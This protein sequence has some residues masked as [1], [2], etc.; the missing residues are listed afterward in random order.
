MSGTR[1]V[2]VD[3]L[4]P[5]SCKVG[6]ILRIIDRNWDVGNP[7]ARSCPESGMM[8]WKGWGGGHLVCKGV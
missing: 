4:S 1:A 8:H 6:Y 5:M 7:E 2:V 3:P